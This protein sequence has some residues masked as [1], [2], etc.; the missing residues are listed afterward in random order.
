MG[1]GSD[2]KTVLVPKDDGQGVMI[3]ACQHHEFS[4]G[5]GLIDQQL[6]EVSKEHEGKLYSDTQVA[7][8]KTGSAM[9]KQLTKSPYVLEFKY[10]CKN[11]EY[12]CYGHMV[13]QLEDCTDV[14]LQA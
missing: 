4:F 11:E 9:K 2:G 3:S 7:T 5:L 13:C 14:L 6:G 12:W 10:S 1:L 8:N